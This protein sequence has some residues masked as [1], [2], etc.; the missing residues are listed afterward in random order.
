MI[1]A[2]TWGM[3]LRPSWACMT[4]SNC[5]RD[6]WRRSFPAAMPMFRL[7]RIYVRGFEVLH[8]HV[9]TGA[10]WQNISDHAALSVKLKAK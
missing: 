2:T 4:S 1:G 3:R 10:E 6:G 5:T 8:S 7:D 9:H